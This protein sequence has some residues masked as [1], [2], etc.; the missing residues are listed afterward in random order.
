MDI[1]I[2]ECEVE[3]Y[4]LCKSVNEESIPGPGVIARGTDESSDDNNMDHRLNLIETKLDSLVADVAT[5]QTERQIQS[6]RSTAY[7]D[8]DAEYLL[9]KNTKDLEDIR[10]LASR[11]VDEKQVL[12]NQVKDSEGLVQELKSQINGL[13]EENRALVVALAESKSAASALEE[14]QCQLLA[15]R[16]TVAQL[17][18]KLDKG[19]PVDSAP[20]GDQVVQGRDEGDITVQAQQGDGIAA[21]VPVPAAMNQVREWRHKLQKTFLSNRGPPKQSEMP[22][23]NDLFSQIEQYGDR[24]TVEQLSY[25]KIVKVLRHIAALDPAKDQIPR[26]EEFKFRER[27]IALVNKWNSLSQAGENGGS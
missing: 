22:A 20:G 27:A 21:P 26:D 1:Q 6:A 11:L 9:L 16:R 15:E 2:D 14:T 7:S 23:M 25:S 18:A 4:I 3:S 10:A 8:A 24:M 5:L 19:K 13:E 12:E 17:R